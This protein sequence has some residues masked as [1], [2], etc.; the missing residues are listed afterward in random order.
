MQKTTSGNFDLQRWDDDGGAV[1]LEL[2][3]SLS[4]LNPK[5]PLFGGSV[6]RALAHH[7]VQEEWELQPLVRELQIWA[8]RMNDE[9]GLRIPEIS[10]RVD[11]LS[12]WRLGHFRYGHNGFGLKGE[13]AINRLYLEREFWGLLGTLCHELVHAW[14]QAHGTA[15]K[16]NYHNKQFREKAAELGL[17][18]DARGRTDYVQPSPF[19]A[20]LS[21]FEVN[22]PVLPKKNLSTRSVGNSKLK[23]WTCGCTKARVAIAD[24]Q[25]ICLKCS[26]RFERVGY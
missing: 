18:V 8:T 14:Q 21:R 19:M 6:Y 13:I 11:W 16:H 5:R 1:C 7:Q 2:E 12:R 10:L 17:I 24:F 25:A 4:G 22:V 26:N 15:G 20:L 9:F 3:S 23:L